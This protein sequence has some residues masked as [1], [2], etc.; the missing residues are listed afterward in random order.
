MWMTKAQQSLR[1]KHDWDARAT[2][3]VIYFTSPKMERR[4]IQEYFKHGRKQAYTFTR[5]TFQKLSLEPAG[6]RMLD[7]G[8][9]IG[10]LFP[11]FIEM[12]AEVWGVD[13][14]EEMINQGAKLQASPNVRFIRNSG[15]DLADIPDSHFDFVFSYNALQS[16][17]KK[18]MV[19][20]YLAET[21]RV[22]KPSGAFQLHF[23]TNKVSLKSYIY[24][25]LPR[26]FR[27]TAQIM[28]RFLLLHPLRGLPLQPP[29]IPG[30]MATF[31]GPGIS[32]AVVER[33]LVQL[34]F[35]EVE[36][37]PDKAYLKGMKFWVIGRRP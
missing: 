36:V 5:D 21:Y 24:Q 22:L 31:F 28:Y 25:H 1:M 2:E 11:G 29:H 34:G 6:K 37:L 3:D 32:P 4:E 15:Y 18:W 19:F 10:R 17:P 30:D 23:M 12:F 26:P 14:S 35:I 9:G 7:I 33:E 13:V 8:C 20:S 16:V 27:R